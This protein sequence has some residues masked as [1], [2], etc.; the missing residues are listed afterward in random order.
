MTDLPA[1]QI[2]YDLQYAR[3]GEGDERKYVNVTEIAGEYA[4]A[5]LAQ[6][7]RDQLE[8]EQL[9]S[10]QQQKQPLQPTTTTDTNVLPTSARSIG[11]ER[12][13]AEISQEQQYQ[14]QTMPQP[15][16]PSTDYD[17]V[18]LQRKSDLILQR[19]RQREEEERQAEQIAFGN[20][21]SNRSQR[22]VSYEPYV[23]T[24]EPNDKVYS[25]SKK[26]LNTKSI[27]FCMFSLG[28]FI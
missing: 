13:Y 26:Q 20:M 2:L 25:R 22:R 6:I 28:Y 15:A 3:G 18:E 1:H 8:R 12:Q 24:Y 10:R 7:E 23:Q 16:Y 9:R 11:F 5:L 19:R 4:D 17:A 14:P 21:D 27:Y